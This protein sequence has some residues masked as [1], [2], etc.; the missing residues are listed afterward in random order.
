MQRDDV[1]L[2]LKREP[3][4][5]LRLHPSNGQ[6]FDI[7]DPELVMVTASTVEF[8]VPADPSR[9]A[10]VNL[11]QIVWIEVLPPL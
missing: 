7:T 1:W 5:V 6:T 11:F 2:T 4:P 8:L 3:N 10:I 9:E